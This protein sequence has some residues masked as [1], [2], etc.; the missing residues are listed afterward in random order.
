[1]QVGGGL[2]G[3]RSEHVSKGMDPQPGEYGDLHGRGAGDRD[4]RLGAT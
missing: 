1:M 4:D 3:G 2:L